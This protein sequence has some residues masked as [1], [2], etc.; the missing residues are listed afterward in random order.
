MAVY[1]DTVLMGMEE[2]NLQPGD[3]AE[4]T[5]ILTGGTLN[6]GA[7]AVAADTHI[8][9]DGSPDLECP[10]LVVSG[11]ACR[12]QADGGT[13]EV[14]AGGTV[15]DAVLNTKALLRV[16]GGAASGITA[17]TG[18]M[19]RLENGGSVDGAA[20]AEGA[21]FGWGFHCSAS[22]LSGTAAGLEIRADVSENYHV[23][24]EE[25]FTIAA[26]LT[27]LGAVVEND[28][29]L[30]IETGGTATGFVAAFS[31][32]VS[33]DFGATVY[34]T[35]ENGVII[36]STPDSSMNY[37]V[38]TEQNV[39]QWQIA[40]GGFVQDGAVQNVRS[41]GETSYMTIEAGGVQNAE[42][43]SRV[44]VSKIRGT[45]NLSSGAVSNYAELYSGG[46]LNAQ[47]GSRLTN[48]TVFLDGTLSLAAGT[49]LGGIIR[50]TGSLVAA[51]TVNA[52]GSTVDFTLTDRSF[53]LDPEVF[54]EVLVNDITLL[55]GASFS[56]T[57][58]ATGM[59][60]GEYRLAGNAADFTGTV[61]CHA[62]ENT[63]AYTLLDLHNNSS[64]AMNGKLYTLALNSAD[65]LVLQVRPTE[66]GDITLPQ[67]VSETAANVY[68]R[69]GRYHSLG[70]SGRQF[71]GHLSGPVRDSGK[72]L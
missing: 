66:S 52:S 8:I 47:A 31:G 6:V 54:S 39:G 29:K 70:G 12:I 28:G 19:L 37:R 55:Q 25:T 9:H 10:E 18:S 71:P 34:G 61:S 57:I 3:T 58:A 21:I 64:F 53:A 41:G 40:F 59:E 44:N 11:E 42:S 51:G 24:H 20:I 69:A 7:G 5:T 45:L 35:A 1:T 32:D 72:R 23:F 36:K 48:A 62:T 27:S 17:N 68:A 16:N 15:S 26:G 63:S 4:R 67:R 46:V 2:L 49:T 38:K 65:E 13:I 33:Y 14:H 30:V 60:A 56:I 50:V 43:G 22:N